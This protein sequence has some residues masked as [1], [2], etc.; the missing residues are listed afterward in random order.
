M[1]VS[2]L[3]KAQAAKFNI[4]ETRLYQCLD[5]VQRIAQ[6]DGVCR[7]NAALGYN[8]FDYETTL[9][10]FVK[11]AVGSDIESGASVSGSLTAEFWAA[12]YVLSNI[13]IAIDEEVIIDYIKDKDNPEK[14]KPIT[15]TRTA[16]IKVLNVPLI[17]APTKPKE[18][19]AY[20]I[21]LVIEV[22]NFVKEGRTREFVMDGKLR[23]AIKHPIIHIITKEEEQ[24]ARK[25]FKGSASGIRFYNTLLSCQHKKEEDL[26]AQ[27]FGY[28]QRK[29][30]TQTEE[31]FYKVSANIKK[32]KTRD[33]KRLAEMFKAAKEKGIL[34]SAER[35]ATKDSYRPFDKKPIYIWQWKRRNPTEGEGVEE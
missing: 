32:H 34:E 4:S 27:V 22:H 28:Q 23:R 16:W 30:N 7:F 21:K 10:G 35:Y 26:L 20:N 14:K 8:Y 5:A 12:L 24:M 15:Q 17:T 9:A 1:Q 11:Q 18:R 6:A 3:F 33:E 13:Y 31:E 2:D 29:S 19:S 25:L